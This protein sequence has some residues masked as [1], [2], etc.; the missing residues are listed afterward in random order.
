MFE[1]NNFCDDGNGRYK[2]SFGH[3]DMVMAEIQ[4]TFVR[5]TVQYKLFKNEFEAGYEINNSDNIFNPFEYDNSY[6]NILRQNNNDLYFNNF[7]NFY[8]I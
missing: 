5:E 7:N 3:D 4:L 1:L 2:A 6:N 8:T